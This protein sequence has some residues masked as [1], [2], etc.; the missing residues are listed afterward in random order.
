MI[1]FQAI[2]SASN[3]SL[4]TNTFSTCQPAGLNICELSTLGMTP[5]MSTKKIYV[6]K[7]SK[8]T[9]CNTIQCHDHHDDI[10]YVNT[11]FWHVLMYSVI[12]NYH[13]IFTLQITALFLLL[14]KPS[15]RYISKGWSKLWPKVKLWR[16]FGNLVISRDWLKLCPNVKDWSDSGNCTLLKPEV[17][18]WFGKLKHGVGIRSPWILD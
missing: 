9:N 7:K 1:H 4:S 6:K 14:K 15:P 3:R 18:G 17:K 13:F 8:E 2:L 11:F 16:A 10:I 5:R 12:H